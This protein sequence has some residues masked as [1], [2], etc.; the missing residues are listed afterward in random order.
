[1]YCVHREV[2]L[3]HGMTKS[4]IIGFRYKDHAE[5]M[6]HDLNIYQ[7]KGCIIDGQVD[8]GVMNIYDSLQGR[9]IS[10]LHIHPYPLEDIEKECLMNYMDLW[11]VS[12]IRRLLREGDVEYDWLLD[13][14]EYITVEP[15]HRS[16]INHHFERLL[17]S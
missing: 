1:M 15:P 2:S 9:P 6:Q 5:C 14:Y 7:S 8:G 13:I 12:D 11:L 17:R 3:Y 4:C 10:K 16:Y